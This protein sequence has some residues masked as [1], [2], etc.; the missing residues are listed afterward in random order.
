MKRFIEFLEE[1]NAWENFERAFKNYGRSVKDY[2]KECESIKDIELDAAFMWGGYK[3][4]S[5]LL[6]CTKR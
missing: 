5:R 3:R 4:R 2:K 1:N 6:E